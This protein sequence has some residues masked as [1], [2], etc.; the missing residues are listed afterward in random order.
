MPA[1]G[2]G[3]AGELG[4]RRRD[5]PKGY[6][7]LWR[8]KNQGHTNT[9]DRAYYHRVR[10][11]DTQYQT[12]SAEYGRW[13]RRL[14]KY[15][16]TKEQY[17]NLLTEQRGCCKVCGDELGDGLRVDHCH[18]T[19]EVRALLCSNCNTGIGLFKEEPRRLRAAALYCEQR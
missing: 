15:G 4:C 11:H 7:R 10:K 13:Y 12:R 1:L 9:Y 19:G 3:L 14:R 18:E 17:M 5:D 8:A 16:I 2:T 6:S